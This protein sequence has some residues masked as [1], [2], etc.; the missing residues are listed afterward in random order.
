MDLKKFRIW[1]LTQEAQGWGWWERE[2]YVTWHSA[3][4][5][6]WYKDWV[7]ELWDGRSE[8]GK[9]SWFLMLYFN[10]N[11]SSK[12]WVHFGE[13]L[14]IISFFLTS[15]PGVNLSGFGTHLHHLIV[16]CI[17]QGFPGGPDSK[18]SAYNMGDLGLIP[19][20]GRSPG[21]GNVWWGPH[22]SLLCLCLHLLIH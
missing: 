15:W 11:S 9:S 18:E 5:R 20:L 10:H 4:H 7:P 12:L 1:L 13:A 22:Y 14:W 8:G 6:Y 2:E 19:G 17:S 21:E 3:Q 16:V